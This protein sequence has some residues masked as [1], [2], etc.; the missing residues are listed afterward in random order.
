MEGLALYHLGRYEEAKPVLRRASGVYISPGH[1]ATLAL[2]EL[3]TGNR[4]RAQEIL[5][6]MKDGGEGPFWQGLVHAALGETEDAFE[7]FRRVDR[8]N[9]WPTLPFRYFYPD[10]LGPLRQ[11]PRYRELLR[12]VNRDWGLNPDGSFPSEREAQPSG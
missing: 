11:D 7:A 9:D 1:L 10:V 6:D 4:A 8:W 3:A 5:A 2:A 12:E